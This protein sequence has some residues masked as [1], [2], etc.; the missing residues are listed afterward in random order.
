MT[1][2]KVFV[3]LMSVCD[4]YTSCEDLSLSFDQIQ[5]VDRSQITSTSET[6][7]SLLKP[8]ENTENWLF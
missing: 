7:N 6:N 4:H 8:K 1:F 2:L 3:H 5:S